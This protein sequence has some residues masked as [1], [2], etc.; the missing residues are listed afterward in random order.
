MFF[1]KI[2]LK[3]SNPAYRKGIPSTEKVKISISC[4][5]KPSFASQKLKNRKRFWI[6]PEVKKARNINYE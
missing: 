4:D 1:D 5:N 2:K 6:R 3:N